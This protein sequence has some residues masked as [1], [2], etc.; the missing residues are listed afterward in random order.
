M[1]VEYIKGWEEKV[2]FKWEQYEY[3]SQAEMGL[4]LEHDFIFNIIYI[5]LILLN[6]SGII[7]KFFYIKDKLRALYED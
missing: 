5:G 3:L 1:H 4:W 6:L 2:K 7:E